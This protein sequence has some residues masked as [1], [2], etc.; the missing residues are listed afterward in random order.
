VWQADGGGGAA[1]AVP[2]ALA[3]GPPFG[4]ARARLIT[5]LPCGK[6]PVAIAVCVALRTIVVNSNK[7]NILHLFTIGTDGVIAP[8][9]TLGGL[10][11]GPLQFNFDRKII[12][13]AFTVPAPSSGP[14]AARPTLLVAD[15][16][17]DR[18]QEVDVVTRAHVGYLC[19][20]GTLK[21]PR[22]VAASR[23][24]IA[25]TTCA[26]GHHSVH[27]FDAVSR[28]RMWTVG[29]Q[30]GSGP[31]KL[32]LPLGV[33]FTADGA[34][35]AVADCLNRRIMV[36]SVVDGSSE[37]LVSTPGIE[38]RDVEEVEGGW[39]VA[40]GSGHR[41]ALVPAAGGE[42]TAVVGGLAGSG[43]G[44]FRSVYSLAL[45]PGLGLL[46]ADCLNDRFQ[47]FRS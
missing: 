27:L 20:P 28:A 11:S 41:V 13:M 37:G 25:V 4:L 14:G 32:S 29:G 21:R 26:D 23:A 3:P 31:R 47:V 40:T 7:K 8:A 43:E 34:R 18:V 5:T 22:G 12:K 33:R 30:E 9:G 24:H 36:L 39:L 19:P 6:G 38:P 44:Q 10:G 42:P 46:V 17:N 16:G 15:G 45:V 35:V 1:A 2:D